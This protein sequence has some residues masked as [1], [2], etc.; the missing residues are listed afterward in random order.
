MAPKATVAATDAT[1]AATAPAEPVAPA[2]EPAQK[3]EAI[4]NQLT[5]L[6]SKLAEYQG[7]QARLEK[8]R[9]EAI[10]ERLRQEAMYRGLQ[11]QTTKTLQ[12]AAKNRKELEQALKDRAELSS[13]KETIASQTTI[14]E[15]LANRVLDADEVK[16]LSYKQREAQLKQREQ[17]LSAQPAPVEP[18]QI[19]ASS[20]QEAALE[21][22]KAQ[23][24]S[25]YF[26]GVEVDP[27]D[28]RIDWASEITNTQEAFRRFNASMVK[29]VR[30]MD[31]AHTQDIVG[32]LK[33]QSEQALKELEAKSQE[34]ATQSAAEIERI[35]AETVVTTR[36]ETEKRLRQLGADVE[37]APPA[38]GAR[39]TLAQQLEEEVPDSLLYKDPKEYARRV[40]AVKK[41]VRE[42]Y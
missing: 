16:E 17:A 19:P 32:Q 15:T 29:I 11:N 26:P 31:D 8:E 41:R 6:Q 4:E 20:Q 18:E 14:L 27:N 42:Q 38:D 5:E 22:D 10:A 28:P 25:F 13:I 30:E 12:E 35:K 33:A 23:F 34:A 21:F 9:N 1:P 24:V 36:K 39:R 2:T 40:E 7:V 3:T 37:G